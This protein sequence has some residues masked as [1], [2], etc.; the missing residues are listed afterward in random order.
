M[1]AALLIVHG[2]IAVALIGAVTHQALAASARRVEIR[3]TGFLARFRSTDA[4][5]YRD[6]IVI[7]F[8]TVSLIGAVLYPTYRSVVRPALQVLDF[9]AANGAFELKEHL[10]ALGLIVLPAYWACWRQPLEPE[11]AA[12]RV[13]LAWIIAFIVWWN[14][15]IGQILV[16]IRGLLT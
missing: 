11:Y 8:V 14:F 4:A 5:A 2:L 16:N 7:L 12:A 1:I 6:A 9:R 15:V 3:R 13:W 10:S